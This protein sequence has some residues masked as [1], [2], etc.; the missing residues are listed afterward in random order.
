M[1]LS[2]DLALGKREFRAITEQVERA[3]GQMTSPDADDVLAG[4]HTL[5]LFGKEE[6]LA[7]LRLGVE[8][9]KG[10]AL[11]HSQNSALRDT[12]AD[13]LGLRGLG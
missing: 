2:N 13:R 4:A 9:F 6:D 3:R 8:R 7:A 10:D 11:T 5:S 12:L 1:K